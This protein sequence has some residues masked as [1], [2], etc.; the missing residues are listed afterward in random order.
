M[1][2]FLINPNVLKAI[3]MLEENGYKAYLV[4]GA[5]RDLILD[6][7]V[8]DYDIST[9]ATLEE[10]ALVFKDY[11]TKKYISKGITIGVSLNHT[12]F[13]L[14]TFKGKTIEEDLLNRDFSINSLAYN[15][16]EGIIDPYNGIYD[17]ANKTLRTLRD[18]N[19]VFKED[20][21]RLLRAIRFHATRGL[22]PDTNTYN[23][24]LENA[25]LL[26]SVSKERIQNE[27]DP[28]MLTSKPS[29]YIREYLPVYFVLF[30]YLKD[31]YKFDQ[32]R[33]EWHNLDVLEHI[34]KVLD[35]TKRDKVLRYA[36]LFHDI[37]KPKCFTIDEKGLGH[38]YNHAKKSEEYATDILIKYCYNH[39]FIERVSKLVLYHD[40]QIMDND[41]SVLKFLY[42]FGLDDLDLFFGLKRADILGQTEKKYYR[43]YEIDSIT[44]R[45][46]DLIDQNKIITLKNLKIKGNDLLDLGYDDKD[47]GRALEIIL[48]KVIKKEL[49]NDKDKLLNYAMDLKFEINK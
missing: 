43:L 20:P 36:A 44:K 30:P 21:I 29:Y 5:L 45:A 32:K 2:S 33:K 11:K 25:Y 31:C 1:T 37:A 41:K 4:G 35:S 26:D 34:L 47:I 27:I 18:A 13:E 17:L 16:K 9:N 19:I 38:F 48:F 6:L 15:P 28:I 7:P 3:S 22:K 24:I 46:K 49:K 39:K 23:S 42:T 40:Y 14:S 12:Y 8:A 10:I